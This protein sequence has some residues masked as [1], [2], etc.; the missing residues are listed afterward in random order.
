MSERRKGR[1]RPA[2][3]TAKLQVHIN[4]ALKRSLAAAAKSMDTNMASMLEQ[5]LS[6]IGNDGGERV[7]AFCMV[8]AEQR[9]KQQKSNVA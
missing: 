8:Y 7:A 2:N 1:G 3:P 4:P 6:S 9:L 5:L